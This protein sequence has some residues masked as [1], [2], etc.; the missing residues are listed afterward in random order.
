MRYIQ[1]IKSFGIGVL[2]GHAV[3][4][5]GIP[6]VELMC[7]GGNQHRDHACTG[8]NHIKSCDYHR[9]LY[10]ADGHA[11]HVMLCVGLKGLLCL[12]QKALS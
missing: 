4:D 11:V 2:L 8:E 5:A 9:H 7:K 12:G 3:G 6:G 1:A 10:A